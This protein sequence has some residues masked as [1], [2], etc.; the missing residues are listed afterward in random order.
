MGYREWHKTKDKEELGCSPS[1]QVVFFQVSFTVSRE[2]GEKQTIQERGDGEQEKAD[3]EEEEEGKKDG[4]ALLFRNLRLS[5]I[6][7]WRL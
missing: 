7:S 6:L 3:N 4:R 5:P 1:N 2:T